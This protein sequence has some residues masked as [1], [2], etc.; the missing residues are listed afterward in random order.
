LDTR[1]EETFTTKQAADTVGVH[2]N[3]ILNWIRDGKIPDARRDWK[4][5]RIWFA[6][7]IEN[8]LRMKNKKQQL[9][10]GLWSEEQ[11][12]HGGMR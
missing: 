10:L 9:E 6:R 5:Y 1:E 12:S 11:E 4:G 7:D 2:K 8:L 3:T